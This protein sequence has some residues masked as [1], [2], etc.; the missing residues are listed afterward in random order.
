MEIPD[1][2]E[3]A[4]VLYMDSGF[5]QWMSADR[6]VYLLLTVY[7]IRFLVSDPPRGVSIIRVRLG[8]AG[9]NTSMG[10]QRAH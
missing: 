10:A 9:T 5:A 4:I 3:E 8:G 6:N 2:P 1:V 7:V